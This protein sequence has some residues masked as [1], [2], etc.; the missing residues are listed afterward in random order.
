MEGKYDFVCHGCSFLFRMRPYTC[1]AGFG[2]WPGPL[3]AFA[4]TA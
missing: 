3:C 1:I 2:L 4:F